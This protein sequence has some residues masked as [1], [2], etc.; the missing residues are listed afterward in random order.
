MMRDFSLFNVDY[1]CLL[2]QPDPIIS[3]KKVTAILVTRPL[4]FHS[5]C[6]FDVLVSVCE[7]R[8][9]KKHVWKKQNLLKNSN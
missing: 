5:K 6:S 4:P 2:K 3:K 8:K 9:W 7:C 1:F